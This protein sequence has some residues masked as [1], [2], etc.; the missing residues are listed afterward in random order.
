MTDMIERVARAMA[1][2]DSGPEGSELFGIHWDE[3]GDGYVESARAAIE[4]MREPTEEM[5]R[6]GTIT[7]DTC[8]IDDPCGRAAE[9]VWADMIQAALSQ[10]EKN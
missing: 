9:H 4:A 5:E 7:L 3:F 10:Q 8:L 2:K 6:L 1:A